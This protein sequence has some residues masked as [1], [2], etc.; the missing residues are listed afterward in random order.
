METVP[1]GPFFLLSAKLSSNS[2]L[3]RATGAD[4]SVSTGTL[5]YHGFQHVLIRFLSVLSLFH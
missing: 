1:K 2:E 3:V 5:G 4:Q